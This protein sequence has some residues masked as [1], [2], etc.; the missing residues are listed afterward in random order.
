MHGRHPYFTSPLAWHDALGDAL[1]AARDGD[2]RVF[3]V[4]GR[5]TCGG[6]RAMVERTLAKEELTEYVLTH[7]VALASAAET[8]APDVEALLAALPKREP[9]PVC[10]YL[11]SDGRVLHSTAG[12]RP[13][14]VL[15]ND[16]LEA[17]SRR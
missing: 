12:G 6:T 3:L 9:T 10:I 1:A 11:A 14:A 5:Q 7:F 17:V 2:K 15:L 13:P 8:T 16:M 4:H